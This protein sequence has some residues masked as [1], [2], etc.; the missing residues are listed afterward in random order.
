M[1]KSK[2]VLIITDIEGISMVSTIE[3]AVVDENS[4]PYKDACVNLMHDVNSAISAL[5]DAGAQKV[6]VCDGHCYG[7]NFV[8]EMLDKRVVQVSVYDLEWAIKEVS[9]M[10]LIG[11]H[12]MAGTLNGFLDHTQNSARIHRYF[13]NGEKIGEMMQAA[14]YGGFFGVP[15]IMMSG[16]E[17][18]CKE[19]KEFFPD[20]YVAPV[21][22]AISRNFAECYPQEVALKNIYTACFE[23]F[24]NRESFKPYPSKLPLTIE[25]EFNR[26]DM[27]DE[28]CAKHPEL[29]RIDEYVVRLVKTEVN[30]YLD[31]LI[32]WS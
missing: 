5:Y 26:A 9:S 2:N 29:T 11:M 6:Y 10:V 21:K 8:K 1:D 19:A 13:Y 28:A 15:C 30:N 32:I 23:A 17:T 20:I 16:D 7:Q 12:A 3:G 4:K 31:V 24:K 18:A 25:I 14:M 27:A 22:K